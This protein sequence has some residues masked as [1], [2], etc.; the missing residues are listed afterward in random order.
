MPSV[1][2]ITN[3]ALCPGDFLDRTDRIAQA[4]P[5]AIV[6]RE[7]DLTPTEYRTLAEQVLAICAKHQTPCIL[8][9][10]VEVAQSLEHDA[11]H[12]PLPVLREL[13]E[14]TRRAFRVLGASCHSVDEAL[15]AQRLGCTYITA[16]HVFETD[17]KRGVPGRGLEFLRAVCQA[18]QI[19]VWAIGGITPE[20]VP[21]VLQAGAAGV[22]VMS[23]L[24][25][26]EIPAVYLKKF[27][28]I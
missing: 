17:C 7:K 2:C 21:S 8:H 26:C 4:R 19:P 24:M 9:R 11:I 25:K 13:S 6:L 23:A 27:D 5:A 22:C 3:R 16:G 20:R 18:V 10:F 12:L 1:L 15:E 14:T 28:A